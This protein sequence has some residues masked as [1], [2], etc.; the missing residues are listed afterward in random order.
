VPASSPEPAAAAPRAA[1]EEVTL[2]VVMPRQR[3][4]AGSPAAD[5]VIPLVHSP[6]DPGPEAELVA[7]E[8]APEAPTQEGWWRRKPFR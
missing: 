7:E 1:V 8:P 4:R 3:P 6:D 2:P 5:T